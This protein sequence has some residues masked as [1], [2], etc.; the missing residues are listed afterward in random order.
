L[1]LQRENSIFPEELPLSSV[2]DYVTEKGNPAN[3]KNVK[4]AY[5]E[6]PLPFLR[7]GLEFVDTPGGG[8]AVTANTATTYGFLPECDAVLFVT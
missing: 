8:S 1:I 4:T 7:R 6:L 3:Q 2:P 5:I